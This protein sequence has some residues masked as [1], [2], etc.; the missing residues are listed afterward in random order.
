MALKQIHE[1]APTNPDVGL[2]SRTF[3]VPFLSLSMHFRDFDIAAIHLS[4][5]LI[6]VDFFRVS[7]GKSRETE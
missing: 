1:V 3:S 7:V 4:Q 6:A 5:A 2:R